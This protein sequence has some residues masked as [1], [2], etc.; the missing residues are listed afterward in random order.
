MSTAKVVTKRTST[1]G[2]HHSTD[3]TH[4]MT[5]TSYYVTFESLEDKST[6]FASSFTI[7]NV[8]GAEIEY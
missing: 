5:T 7:W 3:N 6:G 1:S 4:S 8:G 2:G